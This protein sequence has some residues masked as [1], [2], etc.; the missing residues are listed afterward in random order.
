MRFFFLLCLLL[1]SIYY[2]NVTEAVDTYS[3][4]NTN[5]ETA[6]FCDHIRFRNS[7]P[8]QQWF[9]DVCDVAVQQAFAIG[10][11]MLTNIYIVNP[12][13]LHCASS[14]I[15]MMVETQY[16]TPQVR[17]GIQLYA[18]RVKE[19]T[20]EDINVHFLV[21]PV[22]TLFEPRDTDHC[23]YIIRHQLLVR[24]RLGGDLVFPP[25][26]RDTSRQIAQETNVLLND[27]WLLNGRIQVTLLLA[28][29]VPTLNIRQFLEQAQRT[30][31]I[32]IE[33]VQ[34]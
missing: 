5:L 15:D 11:L 30:L 6:R 7:V 20:Q 9:N 25:D 3:V 17:A 27:M 4:W 29:A 28:N 1:F 22:G 8:Y 31:E 23:R 33:I 26:Y 18:L 12:P 24:N 16:D 14:S 2:T 32:P 19:R 13:I 10:H 34:S 21:H